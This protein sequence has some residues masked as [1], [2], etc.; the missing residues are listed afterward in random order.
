LRILAKY[1]WWGARKWG[2][3]STLLEIK[4]L[5]VRGKV[6]FLI[7][8]GAG[9]T[10]LSE[11]DAQRLGL[12]YQNF[13]R[14]EPALGVGGL[15]NTWVIDEEV[16]LYMPVVGGGVFAA[17]KK[18]IEILEEPTKQKNL[19]SLLGLDFL[20]QLEFKLTFDMPTQAIFLER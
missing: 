5:G 10:T 11:K 14:G 9:R 13:P 12:S 6:D 2:F 1:R 17:S 7:D 20:E 8:S 16:T 15:A 18:G 3:L 19:P 4:K